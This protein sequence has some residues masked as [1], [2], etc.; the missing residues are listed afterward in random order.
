MN[1]NILTAQLIVIQLLG[2]TILSKA[3]KKDDKELKISLN[4]DGSHYLKTTFTAQVWSRYNE[5]NPGTTVF[6]Y[7]EKNTFDIGL[8]R[9]RGQVFGKIHDKVFVYTQ[10]GINNFNYLSA[11]K[12]GIFFHDVLA[13]YQLTNRSMQLGMGL[14]GWTGFSRFSSPA[15]AS[16]LGY[17]APLYQQS[18]ND[19]TDQFLRKLSIYGKGKLGKL[20]YRV[21]ISKPMAAAAYNMAYANKPISSNSEFSF[22]PSKLQSSAYLMYQFFDEESNLTPYMAGTY[23][24]KK[25]V[26]TLGAGVQYQKNALWHLGADSVN[27]SKPSIE[28]DLLNYSVDVFYDAPAGSKGAAIS[29]YGALSHMGFGKNYIRN[30]SVMNPADP[31]SLLIINGGGNGIPLYGTGNVVYVQ[32]AYLLP[33]TLMDEKAGRLQAYLMLMHANYERLNGPMQVFDI[34]LNYYID[35]QRAKLSLDLQNRPIFNASDAKESGRRNAV[36]L[37]FQIAI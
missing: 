25:K 11:R 19:V 35:K 1:K 31:N 21:V 3:Q 24:G 30:A 26:L 15:I 14:T 5:N 29:F 37:Q 12:P 18:T 6:T 20:D 16:I 28:E 36:I 13:E 17:D 32:G 9:V 7:P 2:I 33:S 23:L 22:K 4:E 27:G 34:G 10:V 8:R